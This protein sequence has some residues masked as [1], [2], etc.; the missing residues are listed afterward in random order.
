M[1]GTGNYLSASEVSD[2][3]IGGVLDI[4]SDRL[5]ATAAEHDPVHGWKAAV[6]FLDGYRWHRVVSY[7]GD[8]YWVNDERVWVAFLESEL[9][10]ER[11]GCL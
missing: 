9:L 8:V 7:V 3:D 6:A 4:A 10:A 1:N 5:L 2:A 11:Q